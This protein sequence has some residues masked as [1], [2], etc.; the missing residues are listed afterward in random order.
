MWYYPKLEVD[1]FHSIHLT[2]RNWIQIPDEEEELKKNRIARLI[3]RNDD[4][5]VAHEREVV[6]IEDFLADIAGVYDVIMFTIIFF[7]GNYINFLSKTKWIKQRYKF[8]DVNPDGSSP[9]CPDPKDKTPDLNTLQLK[10]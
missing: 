2:Y 10:K 1:I 3:Y 6:Q 8:L 7:F 4:T 5:T 9:D